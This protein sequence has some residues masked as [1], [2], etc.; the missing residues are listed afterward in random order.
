MQRFVRIS[1]FLL[2]AGFMLFVVSVGVVVGAYLYVAPDLPPV[3]A[4]RDVQMK[5]PMRVYS[6]DGRLMAEFGEERRRPLD[7]EQIPERLRQA[8]IAAED[9]RFFKHPGVDY[10]GLIRASLN[11]MRTR[12][13]TQG[14]S[15]ITMQVARN[16]FLSRDRT[17]VRKISEIFLAL[18]IE[19]DLSK[20]EIL[21]LY[22]NKIFL[23][24]RSFGVAAAAEVYY[25][26]DVDELS[27]AEMAM[28][29]GLPQAPSQANPITN[30]E[31]ASARRAYVLGRMLELGFIEQEE[32]A[33]AVMA[34]VTARH[35]GAVVEFSAPFVAEM[36]RRDMLAR[37]GEDAYNGGYS[38]YTT[39]DSE[40]QPAADR[41]LR[42]GLLAYDRRHGWRGPLGRLPELPE[43]HEEHDEEQDR[44]LAEFIVDWRRHGSLEPAVVAVVGEQDA[45][46]VLR[47]GQRVLLPWE[48]IS[49]ARPFIDRDRTGP[50]PDE[51]AEVLAP[52]DIVYLEP[53]IDGQWWLAQVP[54]VEGSVV[55]IDPHDGAIRAVSGGSEGARNATLTR[56]RALTRL[57]L[58][59]AGAESRLAREWAERLRLRFHRLEDPVA[60][61]S[62]GNQQKVVLA[63]WLATEPKL[64]ILDEPTRGID[65]GTKAEV[66]RLMSELAGLGVAV[67]MI[68]SELP[69]VLGMADRVV[70]MHEG[71]LTRELSRDDADEERVMRAATGVEA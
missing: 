40:M 45:E 3:D 15:T 57:G 9:D 41:A 27:L 20:E 25:G 62:G 67:L 54:E 5:E 30:P 32:Y 14:G 60:F 43:Q 61:L 22:L 1:S 66:H 63:K 53:R 16:F 12:E 44:I 24:H 49:W 10:Q 23:G 2:A 6:R 13:R 34:P 64:L 69:E 33:E 56:M 51:A 11:L 4:L 7:Y 47:D 58:I 28:I 26:K 70:V 21:S 8:V 52:G 46:A 37:F 65:V 29:A 39:V 36:V 18:K 17:Y 55:A 19:R 48:G 68:S 59:R 38:V 31:R 35:H 42:N 50:A 71:R